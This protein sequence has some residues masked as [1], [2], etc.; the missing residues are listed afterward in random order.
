MP[1]TQT[2]LRTGRNLQ[3]DL[4]GLPLWHRK[5]LIVNDRQ[6]SADLVIHES[7][8]L[9]KL[10]FVLR[11]LGLLLEPWKLYRLWGGKGVLS[12]LA[13]EAARSIEAAR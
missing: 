11:L 8:F 2:V 4:T 1:G 5:S 6:I 9:Q 3:I 7:Q 13:N 12:N 10:V